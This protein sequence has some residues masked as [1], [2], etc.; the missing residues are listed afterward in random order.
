ME[1]SNNNSWNWPYP[2]ALGEYFVFEGALPITPFQLTSLYPEL[3]IENSGEPVELCVI[4]GNPAPILTWQDK[5]CLL[6]L[7]Y[8]FNLHNGHKSL[9]GSTNTVRKILRIP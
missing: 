1:A 5:E 4:L 9:L 8:E 6:L 2:P 3:H 7:F